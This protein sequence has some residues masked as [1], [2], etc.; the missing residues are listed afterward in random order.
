MVAEPGSDWFERLPKV[1]LHL[2]V[3]G[4]IPHAALWQLID[5]YGGDP[6]VPGRDDLASH[7]VYRDFPEFIE[8][9]VWKRG[10]IREEADFEL[11]GAAVAADLVR[12]NI[13]YAEAFYTPSDV[14]ATSMSP[15]EVTLA[16]RR[17]LSSVSGV[18]VGLIVDLCRDTGPALGAAT[19]EAVA[20]VAASAGV[21]GIGLGGSEQTF[22]PEP[23][24]AVYERARSL[25]LRT[26]AHAGEVVGAESVWGAVRAL[27]V[28]RIDHGLRA[29]D[30]PELLALLAE[31]RLP[32]TACPGSNVAT[33]A[34][35]TL[36]EH[37]LRRF[38]ESGV[39]VSVNTDDPAMFGLTLT[40]ELAA[41]VDRLGLTR[42]EV[43][44]LTL[45][46]VDSTWLPPERRA[47]LRARVENDPVWSE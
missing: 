8:K 23:Y 47:A 38:L 36:E 45:N 35:A 20:E 6:R 14:A 28:D 15:Q 11:I 25:G 27:R 46:A 22:P 2:H 21:I 10:F 24:A 43:R 32:V 31:R 42:A 26:T 4:A 34:I 9:W 44:T 33:G 41:T 18:D 12:Q 5:K 29:V 16:L 30:D 19:L 13:L 1:E 39:V 40:G 7:F 17:G 3:E 37:P